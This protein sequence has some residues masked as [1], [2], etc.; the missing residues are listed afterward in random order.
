MT[1]PKQLAVICCATCCLILAACASKPKQSSVIQ[2]CGFPDSPSVGAPLWVCDAPIAG[3]EFTAVGSYRQTQAGT[4][5][6]KTHAT[7]AARNELASRL[8]VQVKRM[9]KNYVE[10][11]GV[12]D[13]ETVDAVSSDTSKHITNETLHGTKVVRSIVNP[14]TGV[15]YVAISMDTEDAMIATQDALRTSYNNKKALWQRL[16]A[17]KSHEELDEEIEKMSQ[18]LFE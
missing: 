7:A 2:E 17:K 3:H 15:M 6:Q 18:Q 16:M 9:V 14:E 5:F 8:Q 1:S 12:G 11:T 4:Q 10:T 13:D